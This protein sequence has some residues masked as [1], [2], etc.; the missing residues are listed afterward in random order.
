MLKRVSVPRTRLFPPPALQ[1]RCCC[2]SS[3]STK[4]NRASSSCLHS[5]RVISS[6]F[7]QPSVDAIRGMLG[8]LQSGPDSSSSSC[9][10]FDPP[11]TKTGILPPPPP[12]RLT[13]SA[14][15]RHKAEKTNTFK[16]KV[17]RCWKM[18]VS[19]LHDVNDVY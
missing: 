16:V 1:T 6:G 10:L 8:Q 13:V 17:P 12:P 15:L 2:S 5:V 9:P 19:N 14:S 7:T 11:T 3:S 18:F 4:S